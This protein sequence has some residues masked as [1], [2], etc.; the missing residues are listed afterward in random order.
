LYKSVWRF[1]K[2][3]KNKTTIWSWYPTPEHI[4]KGIYL[5]MLLSYLHTLFTVALFTITKLQIN[6]GAHQLMN[7]WRKWYI[8]TME[9]YSVI[10]N[11]TMSIAWKWVEMSI[12]MLS[13]I[14]KVKYCMFSL[15]CRI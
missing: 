5:S 2:K 3:L 10:K 15:I 13:Q 7:G 6:P 14:Q 9:Y 4:F 11:K 8:N 12:T 1:L